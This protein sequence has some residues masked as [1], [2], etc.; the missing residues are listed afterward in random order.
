[1]D[2]TVITSWLIGEHETKTFD[3]YR[4]IRG[5]ITLTVLLLLQFRLAP[6]LGELD[7]NANQIERLIAE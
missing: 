5:S 4:H 1:M 2:F 3:R 6:V 7:Y